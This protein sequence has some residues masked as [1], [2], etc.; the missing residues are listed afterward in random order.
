MTIGAAAAE[1]VTS[2]SSPVALPVAERSPDVIGD[3]ARVRSP[4][5]ADFPAA[6]C[7][8]ARSGEEVS[9]D[10]IL[11]IREKDDRP[12]WRSAHFKRGKLRTCKKNNGEVGGTL[13][14]K[15]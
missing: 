7:G 4:T 14:D 5:V 8:G 1:R 10:V 12:I 11:A 2:R 15:A 3:A 9:T 13:R 6:S